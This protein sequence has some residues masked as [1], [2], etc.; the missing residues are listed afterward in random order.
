M[1]NP[2]ANCCSAFVERVDGYGTFYA[3]CP[4]CGWHGRRYQAEADARRAAESHD[5]LTNAAR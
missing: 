5:G 3:W 4:T 1:S 2:V